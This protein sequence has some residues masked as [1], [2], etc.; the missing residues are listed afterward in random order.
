MGSLER[1]L[2]STYTNKAFY[3][4]RQLLAPNSSECLAAA[5]GCSWTFRTGM[6][7]HTYVLSVTHW[8]SETID[9]SFDQLTKLP[10][11]PIVSGGE[12]P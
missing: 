6:V 10:R 9:D 11:T 5:T 1:V 2:Q 3:S 8:F 7:V 4:I 12:A